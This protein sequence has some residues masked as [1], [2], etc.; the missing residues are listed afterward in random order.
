MDSTKATRASKTPSRKTIR[1]T[2]KKPRQIDNSPPTHLATITA[3]IQDLPPEIR[4]MI[5]KHF[6][7]GEASKQISDCAHWATLSLEGLIMHQEFFGVHFYIPTFCI[8]GIVDPLFK[9]ELLKVFCETHRH[10]LP[11]EQ[12]AMLMNMPIFKTDI[13]LATSR[14]SKLEVP[15]QLPEMAKQLRDPAAVDLAFRYLLRLNPKLMAGFE[16][17]IKI[18]AEIQNGP[19]QTD[20]RRRPPSAYEMVLMLFKDLVASLKAL[21]CIVRH[22]NNLGQQRS[23]KM[24]VVLWSDGMPDLAVEITKQEMSWTAEDWGDYVVARLADKATWGK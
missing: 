7:E 21:G 2:A 6:L 16:L 15:C 13:S 12:I 4:V 19:G 3:K 14:I 10:W 11:F 8:D 1:T 9:T 24:S 23:A 20:W 17:S 22:V 5:Y 18:A